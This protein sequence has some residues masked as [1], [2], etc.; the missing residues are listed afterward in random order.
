MKAKL[1]LMGGYV[2]PSRAGFPGW[3]NEMDF[4]IQVDVRSAK[5]VI[6]N[7]NPTLIP[8]TVTGETSLRRA[9]LDDLRMSG[10]L[11]ELIAR[12]AEAFAED[13]KFEMI[14][15]NPMYRIAQGHHQLPA[16]SISLCD[17]C[18]DGMR[19]LTSEIP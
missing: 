17:Q 11:G 7:S 13:E 16:R 12:Q 3:G 10:A 15:G 6:Q 14:Y 8:I 2:F 18:W 4:N 19:G 1:F 5:H 9:Y